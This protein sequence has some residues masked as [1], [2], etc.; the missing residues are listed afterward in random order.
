MLERARP[1]FSANKY[2]SILM[3]ISDKRYTLVRHVHRAGH[4]LVKFVYLVRWVNSV[5][6]DQMIAFWLQ[7]IPLLRID[8]VQYIRTYDILG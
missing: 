4:W 5:E 6:I 8:I 3:R 2:V 1:E 7:N